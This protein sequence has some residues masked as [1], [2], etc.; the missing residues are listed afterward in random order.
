MEAQS[1]SIRWCEEDEKISKNG[2]C[3][4]NSSE[5]PMASVPGNKTS[6]YQMW[7]LRSLV[8]R[9]ESTCDAIRSHSLECF[10]IVDKWMS[11]ALW[12]FPRNFKLNE[13]GI[14]QSMAANKKQCRRFLCR[15]NVECAY[16]WYICWNSRRSTGQQ[17]RKR[18]FAPNWHTHKSQYGKRMSQ[19]NLQDREKFQFVVCVFSFCWC[20]L[21]Q[22]I[23][24]Q[25][26]KTTS[27][28]IIYQSKVH[29]TFQTFAGTAGD[30]WAEGEIKQ[31]PLQESA[32][33]TLHTTHSKTVA[34]IRCAMCNL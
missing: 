33:C 25:E 10:A 9:A 6:I 29:T 4:K 32:P 12:E 31:Q 23:R 27:L 7:C 30:G 26:I 20:R 34:L 3:L 1:S 21:A 16:I 18:Y 2:I 15:H 5:D 17:N 14:S 19:K 8:P 24:M 11:T 28:R 22:N 13:I